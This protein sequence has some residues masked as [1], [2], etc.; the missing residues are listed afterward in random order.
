MSYAFG[1]KKGNVESA[2]VGFVTIVFARQ[3]DDRSPTPHST[4]GAFPLS[5]E[6]AFRRPVGRVEPRCASE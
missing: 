4:C 1:V 3:I 5:I 6:S 2:V